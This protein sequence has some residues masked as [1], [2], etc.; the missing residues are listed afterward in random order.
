MDEELLSALGD[1]F[2]WIWDIGDDWHGRSDVELALLSFDEMMRLTPEVQNYLGLRTGAFFAF[3]KPEGRKSTTDVAL[4]KARLIAEAP[5]TPPW[6]NPE[7]AEHWHKGFLIGSVLRAER[8][9]LELPATRGEP[10]SDDSSRLVANSEPTAPLK[11][12]EYLVATG[13][14]RQNVRSLSTR[15]I[16]PLMAKYKAVLT[17][18]LLAYFPRRE[19]LLLGVPNADEHLVEIDASMY[20]DAGITYSSYRRVKEGLTQLDEYFAQVR[21][22]ELNPWDSDARSKLLLIAGGHLHGVLGIAKDAIPEDPGSERKTSQGTILPE[23]TQKAMAYLMTVLAKEPDEP[24]VTVAD[25]HEYLGSMR[26]EALVE[27]LREE[28]RA[29]TELD[30]QLRL[31]TPRARLEA[32]HFTEFV[33]SMIQIAIVLQPSSNSESSELDPT[34]SPPESASAARFCPACGQANIQVAKF[35]FNCGTRLLGPSD[36]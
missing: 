5:K 14:G 27:D 16:A 2:P 18:E 7:V 34:S 26:A 24:G 3:S 25:L 17:D 29:S 32:K 9:K 23:D 28:I 19:T 10:R 13:H 35:C 22:G 36:E 4:G 33:L 6:N 15:F 11:T 1:I 12:L 31:V 21:A 20:T 8:S 30:D